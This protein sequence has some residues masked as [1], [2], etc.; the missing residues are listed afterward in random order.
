[1]K[2]RE[3]LKHVLLL[4]LIS[5]GVGFVSYPLY[6]HSFIFG[7]LPGT[8]SFYSFVVIQTL[9]IC[10]LLPFL[11]SFFLMKDEKSLIAIPVIFTVLSILIFYS[12]AIYRSAVFELPEEK[13]PEG[14]IDGVLLLDAILSS[15]PVS[16]VSASACY[17][18]FHSPETLKHPCPVPEIVRVFLGFVIFVAFFLIGSFLTKKIS[19]KPHF[20]R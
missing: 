3:I 20:I 15:N 5:W 1:M 14:L 4:L 13:K 10:I 9:I 6:Q 8:F 7:I 11:Y 18:H 16:M 19:L 2:W 17:F 12:F